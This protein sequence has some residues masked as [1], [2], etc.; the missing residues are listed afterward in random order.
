MRKI[1]FVESVHDI[2]QERLTQAG[3]TCVHRYDETREQL[4]A[5]VSD[6]FGV[7]VRSRIAMDKQWLDAATNLKFIARSGSGLE[8][9]DLAYAKTRGVEVFSSPEGNAT[10]VGEQAVGMLLMLLNHLDRANRQ[11]RQGIWLRE[12]NRGE[13]LA[14]K[15]VGIIGFGWMGSA[16]AQRLSGF[17]CRILAYDKYKTGYAPIGVEEVTLEALYQ[18]ADVVS[19]HLPQTSET[20]YYANSRF[21][22]S[23]FHP[24]ILIN[25]ARGKNVD[26]KALVQ[27]M[28]IGKVRGACLDVL[29]YEKASLEG[30]ETKAWP[31]ELRYLMESTNTILTPHIAGW[32]HQSYF[33][34]SEVLAT[35]ILNQFGKV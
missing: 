23:F 4:L 1:L 5:E 28:K 32:T 17:G 9:V 7:V 34:L 11:V 8:N 33:K 24:I 2:L 14:S 6:Y 20:M 21:F 27:A 19:L 22:D 26:T 30:L 35:K 25:T 16:F 13:E 15:T 3:Y 18:S 29:E 31:E 12:E 10:A